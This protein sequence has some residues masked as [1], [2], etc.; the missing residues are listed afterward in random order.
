MKRASKVEYTQAA[1]CSQ[2]GC[3][4]FTKTGYL[5]HS[6]DTAS[7]FVC[8]DCYSEVA[9]EFP[10][11]NYTVSIPQSSLD[12]LVEQN[13]K[14]RWTCGYALGT[15]EG[16]NV[17]VQELMETTS[18]SAGARLCFFSPG[19]VA[20]LSK[21]NTETGTTLVGLFRTSPSGRAELTSLDD[22]MAE[23]LL[24]DLLYIVAGRSQAA[25]RSNKLGAE[26]YGVVILP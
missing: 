20:A 9:D 23:G 15:K 2:P 7:R 22:K 26:E 21:K 14:L 12:A 6:S 5:L 11:S 16:S 18:R 19:D 17:T 3:G 25:V 1:E 4:C 10:V 24:S 8:D 13:G